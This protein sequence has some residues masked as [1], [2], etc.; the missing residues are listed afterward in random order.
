M[1][2]SA[3][4][5]GRGSRYRRRGSAG[6]A[7]RR[8]VAG[9]PLGSAWHRL[10]PVIPERAARLRPGCAAT[11]RGLALSRG[12]AG[13]GTREVAPLPLLRAPRGSWEPL[14]TASGS[15]VP[16]PELTGDGEPGGRCAG[17]RGLDW[18]PVAPARQLPPAQGGGRE[19]IERV[20]VTFL[21][22]FVTKMCGKCCG[23]REGGFISPWGL[24][25]K[26]FRAAHA[27]HGALEGREEE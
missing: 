8:V 17:R 11:L 26:S 5:A 10:Y 4:P 12:A 25:R 24:L 22:G 2:G 9:A 16:P 15:V 21:F 23:N 3:G 19:G 7:G 13:F 27:F 18:G 14:R 20:A 1:A 6:A